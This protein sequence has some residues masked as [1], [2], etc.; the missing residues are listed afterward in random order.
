MRIHFKAS[1]FILALSSTLATFA[2][3]NGA[4]LKNVSAHDHERTNPY[5]DQPDAIAG[6][7][8][9]FEQNCSPCHGKNAEGTKKRPPL[10]SERVQHEATDGD[11]HWLL[12][13]GNMRK[14]MP[15]WAKLPDQQLW[16]VIAYVKSLG[17]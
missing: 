4:W 1:V 13:N 2:A 9:I 15:S 7:K 14:G 11:I 16:Q 12:V 17:Q 5:K 6:G 8:R 10:R 3:A